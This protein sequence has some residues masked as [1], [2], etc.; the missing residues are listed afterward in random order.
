[1][2][3][4]FG[5]VIIVE[6]KVWNWRWARGCRM[7]EEVLIIGREM[8]FLCGRDGNRLM[9]RWKNWVLLLELMPRLKHLRQTVSLRGII[10]ISPMFRR[11]QL[12][13]AGRLRAHAEKHQENYQEAS[14]GRVFRIHLIL[15]AAG[16]PIPG[17]TLHGDVS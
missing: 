8:I 2:V 3:V 4:Y 10:Q 9:M 16:I 15:S 17:D 7:A 12:I 5:C 13:G 14:G 1:M 6:G 11:E